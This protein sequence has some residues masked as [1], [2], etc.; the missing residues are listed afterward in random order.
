[1]QQRPSE[2]NPSLER[3]HT[4]RTVAAESDA[5]QSRGRR[6]G[7]GQRAKARLCRRLA[8]RAGLVR[9]EGEVRVVEEIEYL[10][11]EAEGNMFRDRNLLRDVDLGVGEVR[12]AIIVAAGVAELAVGRRIAARP[13]PDRKSAV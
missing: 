7:A 2:F 10:R 3:D 8:G 5:E 1:M 12:S 9:G 13:R 11:V 6:D 4:R